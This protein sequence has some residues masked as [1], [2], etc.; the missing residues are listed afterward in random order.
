MSFEDARDALV[1]YHD[2]GVIDDEEFCLLYD[3]NRSKKP[4]FPYE[5]YRKFDLEEMDNSECKAE[6]RLCKEDIPM[7][8]EPLGIPETSTC[9]QGSVS[10]GIEK[11]CIIF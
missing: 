6:F 8:A 7:L 11:L 10:V 1:L 4:A 3:A 5:E 9:S 2:K